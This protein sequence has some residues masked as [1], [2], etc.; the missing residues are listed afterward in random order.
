MLFGR[1]SYFFEYDL[2]V[3]FEYD[4]RVYSNPPRVRHFEIDKL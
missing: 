2:R 1:P 4:L 3:I